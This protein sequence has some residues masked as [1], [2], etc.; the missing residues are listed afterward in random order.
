MLALRSVQQD[1]PLLAPQRRIVLGGAR[2]ARADARELL[3]AAEA[4]VDHEQAGE[5][6]DA[7]GGVR[8]GWGEGWGWRLRKDVP[9]G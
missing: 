2:A 9:Q 8:C 6:Q 5:V 3:G 1:G 7:G 4:L